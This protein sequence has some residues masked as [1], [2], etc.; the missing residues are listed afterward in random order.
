[1]IDNV[2]GNTT[3]I[4]HVE[5]EQDSEVFLTV[6]GKSMSGNVQIGEDLYEIETK[7]N[8]KHDIT[9]VDPDNNPPH[10]QPKTVEDFIAAGGQIS[11]SPVSTGTTLPAQHARVQL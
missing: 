3:W 6:R 7:G 1:M 4:G 8:D 10:S 11:P 5:G 2:K 9:K